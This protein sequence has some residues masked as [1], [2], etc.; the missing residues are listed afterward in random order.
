MVTCI[1]YGFS[2]LLLHFVCSALIWLYIQG[3]QYVSESFPA[4]QVLHHCRLKF[5]TCYPFAADHHSYFRPVQK[6]YIGT[7]LL[8]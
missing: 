4:L 2:Y 7:I 5:Y 1:V 8:I 3:I 6:F